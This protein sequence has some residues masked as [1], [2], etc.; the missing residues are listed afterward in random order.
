RDNLTLSL[1]LRYDL[2]DLPIDESDNPLFSNPK[3]Y[4]KDRNN[5]APRVG[6]TYNLGQ[7]K[8]TV[9]RGGYGRFYDKTHL[10]LV[11]AVVTAG[12]YSY[13]FLQ[14]FPANAADPGPSQ[15]KRPTD[16]F[17]ANGPV[18]DR[19]LLAQRF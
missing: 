10:E 15:G 13:S 19:A 12:T 3:D 2:E 6:L 9:L 17:L 14:N 8:T 7:Q 4:P 1:G 11:Q 16:P 18:V 5:I